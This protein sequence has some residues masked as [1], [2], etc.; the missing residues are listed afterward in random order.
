[1]ADI[2]ERELDR[3]SRHIE[4]IASENIVSR[5]VL[6]AQGSAITNK[7]IE[8]YPGARYHGGA[9]VVD[10]MER[11]GIERAK[12]LFDCAYVNLQ[13]HSGSQANQVALHALLEP[14]DRILSMDLS[15]G[16]HLSHG[17]AVNQ[18]GRF[19]HVAHYA[20]RRQDGRI[21]P[22]EVS[23]RAGEHRPKLIIA[24]G[25]AY[26]RIIDFAHF[27]EVAD[28]VGAR[29][30]VDMAHIAGL[31][32]GGVHP[33][34]MQAA[35]VVT[36]TT[37]KTLRGARGGLVLSND[38][39][40]G[41]ALDAALFPGV[42]GSAHLHT[43]AAKTVCLGEALRPEFRD[44]AA[45]VVAN[46]RA[47]AAGLM[48]RGF[49]LVSG[50]TDTHIVLLDLRRQGLKGNEVADRL[51]AAGITSNKNMVPFDTEKPWITSGVRLGSAAGTSRGFGTDEFTQIADLIADVL[52]SD[53]A[54]STG[55]PVADVRAQVERL[56]LAH[57]LYQS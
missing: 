11:L 44:Y 2:V 18:S 46:A 7:T 43:M 5:A 25:S 45:A 35:H 30:L 39:R 16:G 36:T 29:L 6:E 54:D 26:P 8:G 10:D 51:E 53:D 21:D 48:R 32:A 9:E 24:G 38:E 4:L 52:D 49:D 28:A 56:C 14:G 1:M 42:Q 27:R 47:L 33:S 41:R 19:Y 37:T 13:P 17:A 23:A 20:V 3:Q 22:D 40:L 57:P 12:T 31:V 50:G 55:S 34:P 15:A